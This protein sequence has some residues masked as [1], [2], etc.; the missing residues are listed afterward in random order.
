MT[1]SGGRLGRRPS[2][3]SRPDAHFGTACWRPSLG[4]DASLRSWTQPI[5]LASPGQWG[6][7]GGSCQICGGLSVERL[8][9]PPP[10]VGH[11]SAQP[12]SLVSFG[13]VG[14]KP[15]MEDHGEWSQPLGPGVPPFSA[16]RSHDPPRVRSLLSPGLVVLTE[17]DINPRRPSPSQARSSRGPSP[18]AD[19][20]APVGYRPFAGGSCSALACC[21]ISRSRVKNRC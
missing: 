12:W 15:D 10:G 2:A 18:A 21:S 5:H 20:R 19:S 14:S 6:V 13:W 3:P 4:P 17:V 16:D 9:T 1:A 7:P 11:A 8:A